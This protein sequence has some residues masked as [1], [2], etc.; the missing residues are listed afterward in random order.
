MK[1]WG[2]RA[3][4]LTALVLALLPPPAANAA[5]S[6]STISCRPACAD[7]DL[8]AVDFVDD[9]TGWAAGTDGVIVRTDNAG[10]SWRRQSVPIDADITTLR[11]RDRF[12]GF[13]GGRFR[14]VLVTTDGGRNWT[15]DTAVATP[16][17]D[18]SVDGEFTFALGGR[19]LFRTDDA[20]TWTRV[21]ALQ[22]GSLD[23]VDDRNGWAAG[24]EV[25]TTDDGGR[26]WTEIDT[27]VSEGW[28][29]VDFTSPTDGWVAGTAGLYATTD[30]GDTWSEL[31][32]AE[33]CAELRDAAH[34]PSGVGV[35]AGD[36][37][38]LAETE[39]GGETW[40]SP[41]LGT[42]LGDTS[43]AAVDLV[44]DRA[45]AVTERGTM[46]TREINVP[47]TTTPW[48]AVGIVLIALALALLLGLL[49]SLRSPVRVRAP[50]AMA[51]LAIAA[52]GLGVL[53]LTA[54]S[55]PAQGCKSDVVL[56]A[57]GR[58]GSVATTS[59]TRERDA[60]STTTT[61]G[62]GDTATTATTGSGST[63]PP[64]IDENGNPSPIDTTT[65]ST[66]IGRGTVPATTT[67]TAPA[68]HQPLAVFPTF[69]DQNCY[70]PDGLEGSND[71]NLPPFVVTLDNTKGLEI[72]SFSIAVNGQTWNQRPWAT[73]NPLRGAVEPGKTLDVLVTPDQEACWFTNAKSGSY[74]LDITRSDGPLVTVTDRVTGYMIPA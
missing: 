74:F 56:S 60:D 59:T 30:G 2:L 48:R 18:F 4:V 19:S 62:G 10:N 32:C 15:H 53:A 11:F 36:R 70:G 25:L 21:G 44:G 49:M 31:D 68:T 34:S 61:T 54:R 63:T 16:V 38:L 9:E 24:E 33:A 45:W 73:V 14:G 5:G 3:F 26:T 40:A 64:T 37:G 72:V 27:G 17:S 66:T 58:G 42:E 41:G 43:I 28:S 12:T 52:G 57:G 13:A 20:K 47:T 29:A 7:A 6:W 46:L 35:V 50:V 39:D 51:G 55:C 71:D 8:F 69:V 1:G 23:F 67:T 22:A 65:T